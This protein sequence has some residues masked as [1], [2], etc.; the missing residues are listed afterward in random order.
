MLPIEPVFQ[1]ISRA[2][3]SSDYDVPVDVP[4]TSTIS[5]LGSLAPTNTSAASSLKFDWTPPTSPSIPTIASNEARKNPFRPLSV[6]LPAAPSREAPAPPTARE[7]E[8]NEN[9]FHS[10]Q[11][12]SVANINLVVGSTAES[13]M[14]YQP[15]MTEYYP[16]PPKGKDLHGLSAPSELGRPKP[17]ELRGIH[18]WGEGHPSEM[19]SVTLPAEGLETY[20]DRINAV[21]TAPGVNQNLPSRFTVEHL[22]SPAEGRINHGPVILVSNAQQAG[23]ATVCQRISLHYRWQILRQWTQDSISLILGWLAVCNILG[24]FEIIVPVV[25]LLSFGGSGYLIYYIVK[26]TALPVY[27]K[28]LTSITA[29]F[30][31]PILYSVI[32]AYRIRKSRRWVSRVPM[33]VGNTA[34]T[35]V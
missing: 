4:S 25:I 16:M 3:S 9:R 33:R 21:G 32:Y 31:G 11:S 14:P 27:A 30:I 24:L 35:A 23:G 6:H 8:T 12:P 7:T 18:T 17:V 22:A 19:H 34:L 1:G 10:V 13:W 29:G 5:F 2:F 26:M 15:V 20:G 28:V